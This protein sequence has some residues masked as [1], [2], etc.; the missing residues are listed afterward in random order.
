MECVGTR[1]EHVA[2]LMDYVGISSWD[3]NEIFWK[4][5]EYVGASMGYL[6]I[7]MEQND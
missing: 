5:K 4:L 2:Q 7:S 3:I 6:G 1:I